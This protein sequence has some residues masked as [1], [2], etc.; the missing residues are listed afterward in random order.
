MCLS[1][2]DLFGDWLPD[3]EVVAVCL[4]CLFG[5]VCCVYLLARVFVCACSFVCELVVLD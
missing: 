2:C 3:C 5:L 4:F 1:L